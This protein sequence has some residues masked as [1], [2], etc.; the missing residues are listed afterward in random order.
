MVLTFSLPIL[1][2]LT[3]TKL[4][5]HCSTEGIPTMVISHLRP[6]QPKVSSWASPLTG[7]YWLS[8]NTVSLGFYVS[9]FTWASSH[10][11]APVFL[12]DYPLLDSALT[13]G[14]VLGPFLY[15]HS[16]PAY[17]HP[18]LNF[19]CLL[20]VDDATI[21][22]PDLNIHLPPLLTS[23]LSCL[24]GTSALRSRPLVPPQTCPLPSLSHPGYWHHYALGQ[25]DQTLGSHPWLLSL[26]TA[27]KSHSSACGPT[28]RIF[29]KSIHVSPPSCSPAFT[30]H[31]QHL[32]GLLQW[33]TS[34]F[35]AFTIT[36]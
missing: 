2:Q 30:H 6:A 10:S 25:S 7:S 35:S 31:Y 34:A 27:C 5:L 13:T 24:M 22:S 4:C 33:R 29:H 23:L 17:S 28:F 15:M 14:S 8:W 12:A 18:A 26:L 1:P 3:P 11:T 32:P 16:L 36:H 20:Y 19:K 21:S 9:T